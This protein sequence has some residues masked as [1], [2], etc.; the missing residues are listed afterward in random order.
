VGAPAH[1]GNRL[2]GI[3]VP[4]AR[5]TPLVHGVASGRP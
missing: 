4:V 1:D 5:I 2:L 3:V